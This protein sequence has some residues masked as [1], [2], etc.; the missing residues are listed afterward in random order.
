MRTP[1]SYLFSRFLP[2]QVRPTYDV[3]TGSMR[4][5]PTLAGL[6]GMDSRYAQVGAMDARTFMERTAKI[7]AKLPLTENALREI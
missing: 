6:S 4:I 3:S 5:I 2:E 7:T 1:A